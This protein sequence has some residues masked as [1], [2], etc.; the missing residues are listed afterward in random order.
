MTDSLCVRV[1]GFI[2][3]GMLKSPPEQTN[4]WKFHR[5]TRIMTSTPPD[6]REPD[7]TREQLRRRSIQGVGAA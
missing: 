7:P 2:V 1:I 6:R 4:F 3:L 5:G